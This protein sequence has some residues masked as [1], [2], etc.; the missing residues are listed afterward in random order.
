MKPYSITLYLF[1]VISLLALTSVIMPDDGITI[2]GLTLKFPSLENVLMGDSVQN[3]EDELV[4]IEENETPEQ[5]VER[6]LQEIKQA[7]HDEF[8]DF[9]RNNP[10]R[11]DFPNDD[12]TLF[13]PLFEALEKASE[14]SVR[15]VHYGDSQI[16]EDRITNILR[17]GLQDRF[18]GYG[19]GLLPVIQTVQ[20]STMKQS[21]SADLTRYLVYG[22]GNKN[23]TCGYGPMGM[24]TIVNC[25]VTCTFTSRQNSKTPLARHFS[26]VKVLVTDVKGSFTAKVGDE[27]QTVEDTASVQK[28]RTLTFKL[29]A[30][31]SSVTL[32]MNGRAAVLGIMLDGKKGVKVDNVPMRGCAGTVFT[33]IRKDYLADYY[34][35]NNVSLIILQYGGN[36]MPYLK[37][38]KNIENFGKRTEAQIRYLKR[39]AP[40]AQI[41][42]IGPSDMT[43]KVDGV[44]RTY[45]QLPAVVDAL[46]N[47]AHNS[48]AAYW[49]L[50]GVMGGFNSMQA[51]AKTGLAGT[52]YV[53]FTHKGADKVGDMLFTAITLYYDYYRFRKYPE[54]FVPDTIDIAGVDSAQIGD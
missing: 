23:N 39:M 11:I 42:F 28:M 1:A 4:T 54:Q 44:M 41:L 24:Q 14:R 38:D 48:G 35:D 46:C 31:Q 49:D 18:S 7:K 52:D 8:I 51:W 30:K 2:G 47:A 10:A 25:P 19:V 50:Y 9:F 3:H 13:D 33:S 36:A 37:G 22:A 26:E 5:L 21:C 40:H 27:T 20:T 43:T 16:E 32:Q 29:P 45:P 34:D 15:I 17:Q 53:H 12:V 6:R